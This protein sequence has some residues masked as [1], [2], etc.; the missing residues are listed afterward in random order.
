MRASLNFSFRVRPSE[1]MELKER[2]LSLEEEDLLT[3]SV[4]KAKASKEKSEA[5]DYKME[6]ARTSREEN[7]QLVMDSRT[8]KMVEQNNEI[9]VEETMGS[10]IQEKSELQAN[11][12]NPE[13]KDTISYLDLLLWFN[14]GP[15]VIGSDSKEMQWR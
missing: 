10:P 15:D 14:G 5:E 1:K 8:K 3:R 13:S 12:A 4:K 7:L 9:L 6:E 11:Q 2:N